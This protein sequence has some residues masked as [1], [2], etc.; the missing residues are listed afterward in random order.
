MNIFQRFR[1]R[2]QL[3]DVAESLGG[4]LR[5]V[6]HNDF[7]ITGGYRDMAFSITPIRENKELIG[8]EIT[9]SIN[10]PNHKALRISKID[11]SNDW[12]RRHAAGE[13][14]QKI[15]HNLGA[16]LNLATNDLIFSS[17]YLTDERKKSIREGFEGLS[18]G[19]IYLHENELRFAIPLARI[20]ES[21]IYI[22][23]LDVLCDLKTA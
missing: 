1:F 14:A 10:N 23:C 16:T 22:D 12:L 7:S 6:R 20:G 4:I 19:L 18:A 11:G 9:I 8:V 13:T 3:E 17:A 15:D 2:N 5:Y 21:S